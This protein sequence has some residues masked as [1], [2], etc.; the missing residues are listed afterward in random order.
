MADV[1]QYI[2]LEHAIDSE[3]YLEGYG[4]CH[5]QDTEPTLKKGL[6]YAKYYTESNEDTKPFIDAVKSKEINGI[7]NVQYF[8]DG[9]SRFTLMFEH[10]MMV[11]DIIFLMGQE[12][13]FGNMIFKIQWG[14][15]SQDLSLVNYEVREKH[16]QS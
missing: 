4:K 12:D 11:G 16:I 14:K 2:V 7:F 6:W 9:C 8:P 13:E 3:G 15:L 10:Y 5:F 1:V